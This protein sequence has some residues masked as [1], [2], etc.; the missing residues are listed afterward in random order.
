MHAGGYLSGRRIYGL[1]RSDYV[2]P[3]D[4]NADGLADLAWGKANRNW[5]F[6]LNTGNG[7]APAKLIDQV[8][9]G[10]N[11][12]VRFE[13]WNGDSF[14][15]L[16]YPSKTLDATAKWM[17]NQNHFGREFAAVSNTQVLAGN[18]GGDADV[19]QVENDASI[20]ARF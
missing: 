13:D 20:F 12:L 11:K 2:W 17:I 1:P 10:I 15:D 19:D 4:I 14:P 6:Q 3:V 7:F 18:V 16:I 5:Y 9:D 8:P